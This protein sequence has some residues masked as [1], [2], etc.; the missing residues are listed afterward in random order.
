METWDYIIVGAGTAGSALAARLSE[1]PDCRVLLIE[2]GRDTLGGAGAGELREP[3]LMRV[4]QPELLE[5]YFWNDLQAVRCASQSARPFLRGRAV[6]G[7][8]LINGAI[9]LRALPEDYQRWADMGCT[10]WSAEEVQAIVAALECDLDRAAVGSEHSA[11]AKPSSRGPLPISR[12]P[13]SDWSPLSHAF[14]RAARELGH[15]YAGDA[16]DASSSGVSPLPMNV[17]DGRKVPVS[18][19]YL[20]VARTRENLQILANTLVGRVLFRGRRAVGVSLVRSQGVETVYGHEVILCAGA[21]HSPA[22][23]Q[24]SGIG[25]S[26]R[27]E[28][29]GIQPVHHL[30]GVGLNLLDHPFVVLNLELQPGYRVASVTSPWADVC[31]RYSSNHPG[32]GRNDMLMM[33]ASLAPEHMG[34]AASGS[35]SV[36]LYE[37]F[38]QG[39][40]HVRSGDPALEPD[41]Q[42]RLLCDERDLHRLCDGVRHLV[43]LCVSQSMRDAYQV[44][45]SSDG[46]AIDLHAMRSGE[47]LQDWVLAHVGDAFHIAGTCRM[48]GQDQEF[49]VV[50]PACRVHGLEGI[51]VIDASIMP[52]I[53]RA[54]T[55]LP[56]LM[57]AE[58]M[59]RDLRVK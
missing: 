10:G 36:C 6:G 12:R 56:T 8:S 33:A 34:G 5:A 54:N 9:A 23:L 15:P 28:A 41:M 59:A 1:A 20:E 49:A 52:T 13:Q 4:L 40:L 35:V 44:A 42:Q 46:Q 55:M 14:A 45:R 39:E 58:K 30:P 37:A 50:D 38:S 2:A 24:R 29:A 3:S 27:L 25:A 18:D 26:A 48:G 17:R 7:S 47:D 16:N 21:V 43:D 57:I 51:R 22:I 31:V 32:S 11:S 53:P 19:A